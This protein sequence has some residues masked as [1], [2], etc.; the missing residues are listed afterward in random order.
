M[1]RRYTVGLGLYN[2]TP[3]QMFNQTIQQHVFL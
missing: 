3:L 2:S 1:E